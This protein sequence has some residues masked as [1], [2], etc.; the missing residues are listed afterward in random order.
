MSTRALSVHEKGKILLH[1]FWFEYF[2]RD[3]NFAVW[4]IGWEILCGIS[5]CFEMAKFDE[6]F[7]RGGNF[8]G[9]LSELRILRRILVGRHIGNGRWKV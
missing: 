8:C 9:V 7:D 2:M 5:Y 6:L 4:K 1:F 3:H